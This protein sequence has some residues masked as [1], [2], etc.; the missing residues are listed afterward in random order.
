MYSLLNYVA[1]DYYTPSHLMMLLVAPILFCIFYFAL[2]NKTEKTKRIVL[3][4]LAIV[5]ALMYIAYKIVMAFTFDVFI[6]LKELPLHLCNLNLIL[7]PLA[8][9]TNNKLLMSYLYY[10]FALAV[11]IGTAITGVKRR[12]VCKNL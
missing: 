1:L 12:D 8:I 10:V 7:I 5:N 2:R 4:C 9:L 3:L 11:V 6:I